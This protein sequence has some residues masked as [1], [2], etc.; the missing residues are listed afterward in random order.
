MPSSGTGAN[1]ASA[2]SANRHRNAP[3]AVCARG[4]PAELSM[5]IS[6]RPSSAAT[7]R[8]RLRSGVTSAAVLSFCSS[9]SRSISAMAA[10]SSPGCAASTSDK[11]SRPFA[12][13]SPP[14]SAS[15]RQASVVGAGRSVSRI[16]ACRLSGVPSASQSVTS[17]RAQPI[18]SSNCFMP[19]CGWPGSSRSQLS[20]S[21][22]WSSAGR[23]TEPF[24][25]RAIARSSAAVAGML[26]VE[27]A[28][29]TGPVGGRLCN[30]SVR[31]AVIAL[32][33]AAGFI[34]PSAS[35]KAGH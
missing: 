1:P 7:R 24:G 9:C 20:S 4:R 17:V 12:I 6:Q 32:R 31:A 23:I 26:P 15:A 10:A 13:S 35:S 21:K 33:R 29:I 18:R 34:V 2:A 3:V 14:P 27:P 19:N 25:R 28:A 16:R 8:A 30:L 5:A 11:P 22:A